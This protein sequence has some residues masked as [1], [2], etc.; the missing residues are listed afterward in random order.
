MLE[1]IVFLFL[2]ILFCV[3]KG[4]QILLS[5]DI[6]LILSNVLTEGNLFG[7]YGY[8]LFA[9]LDNLVDIKAGSPIMP[10]GLGRSIDR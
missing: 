7:G 9:G 8:L 2:K 4:S 3:L 10:Y 5:L 6:V 1:D